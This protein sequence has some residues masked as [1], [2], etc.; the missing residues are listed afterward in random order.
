VTGTVYKGDSRKGRIELKEFLVLFVT[1]ALL[2]FFTV[3]RVGMAGKRSARDLAR[4]TVA[5]IIAKQKLF[6]KENG[7]YGSPTEIGFVNPFHDKSVEFVIN[8]ESEFVITAREAEQIDAFGDNIP[9]NE[10]FIGDA[11]GSIEYNKK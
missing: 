2:T 10:Y 9:G 4:K 7:R 6:Y 8:L 3:E 1:V 11:T 5:T